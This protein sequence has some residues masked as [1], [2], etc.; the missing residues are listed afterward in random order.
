[1]RGSVRRRLLLILLLVPLIALA[2]VW[3]LAPLWLLE[4]DYARLRWQSGMS[5][6]GI[7]LDDH[8]WRYLD[9]GSGPTLVLVHGFTGSKENWLLVAPHLRGFR[10]LAPDLPGWGESDR[11]PG[12]DYGIRAQVAR[13]NAFLEALEVRDA[14]LVGHSMGGHIAGVLASE[15]AE[16]LRGLVLMNSA[17]VEFEE[18]DFARRLAAGDN[19]FSVDSAEAYDRWL[20]QLFEVRPWA[21]KPVIHALGRQ[22]IAQ[23]DFLDALMDDLAR[24]HDAYLLQAR[25][26]AIHLPTLVLWCSDDRILDVSSVNVL[27]FGLHD[28]R[29]RILDGCGHMPMMEKP[30]ETAALLAAFGASRSAGA[31]RAQS[32]V[33]AAPDAGDEGPP[34]T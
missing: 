18:N 23:R 14:I 7:R 17:G 32:D 12:A 30:V 33:E 5:E 21:P 16:R 8:H 11:I 26:P 2:L 34:R 6:Y 27:A 22:Q 4:A 10:L 3:L 9:G 31:G 15:N 13:L 24:G 20:D 1:M 25:L 29:T 19:P 28:A